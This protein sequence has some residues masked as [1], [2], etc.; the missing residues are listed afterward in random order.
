MTSSLLDRQAELPRS[1]PLF[2]YAPER[3]PFSLR[4]WGPTHVQSAQDLPPYLILGNLNPSTFAQSAAGWSARWQGTEGDTY[5]D[6]AYKAETQRWE[7]RQTWCG[8]NGGFSVFP[9]RMSLD[10]VIAQALYTPC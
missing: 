9:A 7:I 5:F 10:K 3:R 1:V 2:R 8:L 4:D 6:V